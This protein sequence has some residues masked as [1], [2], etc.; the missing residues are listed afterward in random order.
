MHHAVEQQ[1]SKNLAGAVT[2]SEIHSLDNLRAIPESVNSEIHLSAI[3]TEWNVFYKKF[4]ESGTTPTKQQLLDQATKI[5]QKYGCFF[6]PPL[7]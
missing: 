6:D 7:W 1:A 2:A 5:D 3:R 4:I